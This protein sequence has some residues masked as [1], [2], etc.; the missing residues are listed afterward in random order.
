M[1]RNL[2]SITGR[3]IS[4]MTLNFRDCFI[5]VGSQGCWTDRLELLKMLET[6][7]VDDWVVLTP[8]IYFSKVKRFINSLRLIAQRMALHLSEPEMLVLIILFN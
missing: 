4:S 1:G 2:I 5:P 8:S 7:Y 6:P 3:V